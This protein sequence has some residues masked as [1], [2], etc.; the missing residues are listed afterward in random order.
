M[1]TAAGQPD[2][3]KPGA[4]LGNRNSLRHGLRAGQLPPG[5]SGIV[6][7]L[8]AFR[9]SLE[10]AVMVNHNEIRLVDAASIS[11][12]MRWERHARLAQK[13]LTDH[14][15]E[16]T[17]ADRLNYSKA[18]AQASENRDRAI[19]SLDIDAPAA[20]DAWSTIDAGQHL[21]PT[22][23]AEST[24]ERPQEAQETHDAP[25]AVSGGQD[26]AAIAAQDGS[27]GAATWLIGQVL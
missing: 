19:R 20:A 27:P 13:W 1:T 18:V 4:P 6:K 16:L 12:A 21:P 10:D 22:P 14:F 24:A 15:D 2:T 5:C 8:G 17:H 25:L 7:A 23:A 26:N 3:A 9:R 11:T